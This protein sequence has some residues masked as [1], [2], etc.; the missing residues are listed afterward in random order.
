MT[1]ITVKQMAAVKRTAMNVLPL[2][3]KKAKLQAKINAMLEEIETLNAQIDIQQGYVKSF[4]EGLTTEQLV[5][6]SESGAFTPNPDVVYYDENLHTY[7]VKEATEEEAVEEKL[8]EDAKAFEEKVEEAED[9]LP[10]FL[11]EQ[12]VKVIEVEQEAF[13]PFAPSTL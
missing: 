13:D 10:V 12:E 6:R 3:N 2:T 8:A 7:V 1:Q 11:Q 9:E 5:V 4:T